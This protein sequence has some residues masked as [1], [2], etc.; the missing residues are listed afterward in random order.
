MQAVEYLSIGG[1]YNRAGQPGSGP[2]E[3]A[4]INEMDVCYSCA[5]ETSSRC[6]ALAAQ[7][8]LNSVNCFMDVMVRSP[9]L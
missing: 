2:A 9:G 7:A 3:A 6:L 1:E 4:W 5:I 8:R